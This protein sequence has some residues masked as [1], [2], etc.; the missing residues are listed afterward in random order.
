[1]PA[2]TTIVS[3]SELLRHTLVS[4]VPGKLIKA[5]FALYNTIQYNT[6]QYNKIDMIRY[7]ISVDKYKFYTHIYIEL[8]I[9]H[10]VSFVIRHPLWGLRST[11]Q[12]GLG[13]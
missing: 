13:L 6:I 10:P 9:A 8:L 2:R 5:A 7:M 12:H 1:M 3:V 11:V 4:G